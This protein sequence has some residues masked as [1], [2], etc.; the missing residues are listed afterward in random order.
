MASQYRYGVYQCGLRDFRHDSHYDFFSITTPAS[1]M[2]AIFASREEA[3]ADAEARNPKRHPM[4]GA[5]GLPTY[6]VCDLNDES[7]YVTRQNV[8][9]NGTGVVHRGK[10]EIVKAFGR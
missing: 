4:P 10:L 7:T 1:G 5:P 3:E 6:A 2:V 9:R 8:G